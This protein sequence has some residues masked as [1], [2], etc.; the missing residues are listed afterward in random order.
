M[1]EPISSSN[2]KTKSTKSEDI[3]YQIGRSDRLCK[4]KMLEGELGDHT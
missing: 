3:P 4:R 2:C 1:P